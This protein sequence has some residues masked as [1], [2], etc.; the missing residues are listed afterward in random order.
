MP[1]RPYGTR[2]ALG[3]T[4]SNMLPTTKLP[5]SCLVDANYT[6]LT[7]QAITVSTVIIFIMSDPF[8]EQ[9]ELCVG[10]GCIVQYIVPIGTRLT[11][12]V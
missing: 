5:K 1:S 3:S 12:D 2:Y 7:T 9:V 11:A 10:N 8:M 4:S 6:T